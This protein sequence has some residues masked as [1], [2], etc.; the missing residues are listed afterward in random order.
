MPNTQEHIDRV[1]KYRGLP[2]IKMGTPC[3]VD[4][5]KGVIVGGNTSANLNVLFESNDT[6]RN[7]HPGYKMR[8]FNP[9]G[10]V[11]YESDDLYA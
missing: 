2:E 4:G 7:C 3:E 10:G 6:A 8:I 9:W 1:C 5:K 11:M